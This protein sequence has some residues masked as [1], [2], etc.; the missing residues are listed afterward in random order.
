M[1]KLRHIAIAVKDTEEAAKFYET[2]FSMERV[3]V[4][5]SP[6][7]DGLYLSDGVMCLALLKYKTEEAAGERGLDYVGV[8]HI[9][10]W[11]DDLEASS[12]EIESNGGKFFLDLPLEKD[13]LY[14]ERKFTDPAGVIFDISQNGWVGAKK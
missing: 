6:I 3:G 1:A 4:T 11:V 5:E 9:G 2:V 14:Y 8:H 7:A 10:F 12:A 13:S